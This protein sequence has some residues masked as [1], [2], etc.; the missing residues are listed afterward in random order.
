MLQTL[1]DV[2]PMFPLLLVIAGA[3]LAFVALTVFNVEPNGTQ[4][5]K[6]TVVHVRH[7][8]GS[9]RQGHAFTYDICMDLVDLD[10]L[11]TKRCAF[12]PA[13]VSLDRAKYIKGCESLK[14]TVLER[15]HKPAREDDKHR[16]LLL[17]NLAAGGHTFNPISV[18]YVFDSARLVNIVAEVTNI[19]WLEKTIY[20]LNIQG[21]NRISNRLHPKKLHVS[22]FNPHNHQQ[23]EFDFSIT[24][25]PPSS[26]KNTRQISL[27]QLH[28]SIRVHDRPALPG[29]AVM[30]VSYSLAASPFTTL[31]A[32]PSALTIFRIHY[33]A[34]K[35][36]ARRFAVYDHPLRRDSTSD[37]A[38]SYIRNTE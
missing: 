35:L 8:N 4:R 1:L 12:L 34:A 30:D 31:R 22:P 7:K 9:A 16:V 36:W 6:G 27:Q 33:Q 37:D 13:F 18:Y 15:L 29:N 17:T 10:H 5:F 24:P 2:C 25:T 26:P 14:R 20:I 19:P 32:M 21:G 3:V 38:R 28:F 11:P 23:Y